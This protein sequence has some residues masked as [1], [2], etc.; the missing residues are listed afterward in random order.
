MSRPIAA[1]FGLLGLGIAM[2]AFGAHGLKGR[3]PD[4]ALETFRTGVHYHQIGALAL[5]AAALVAQSARLE[6]RINPALAAIAAGVVIFSATLTGIAL[7][8]PRWLG[9]ITPLGGALM[10]GACLWVAWVCLSASRRQPE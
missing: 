10:I 2:G 6:T 3:I 1:G 7:G 5:I 9:A 8:G 4:S